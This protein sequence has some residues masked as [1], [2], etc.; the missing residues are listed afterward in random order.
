MKLEGIVFH[1]TNEARKNKKKEKKNKQKCPNCVIKPQ[2]RNDD[3]FDVYV[4]K[5]TK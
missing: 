2:K 3:T 4:E 1:A 5:D